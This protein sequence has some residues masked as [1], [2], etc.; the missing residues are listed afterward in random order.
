MVLLALDFLYYSAINYEVCRSWLQR[1]GLGGRW[2][3]QARSQWHCPPA[4][5]TRPRRGPP[6]PPRAPRHHHSLGE[7]APPP[8]PHGLH[9]H[10]QTPPS[11]LS[12]S[13]SSGSSSTNT[14][15]SAHLYPLQLHQRYGSAD[16]LTG[17]QGSRDSGLGGGWLSQGP[18]GCENGHL[19]LYPSSSVPATINTVGTGPGGNTSEFSFLSALF[20]VSPK[21]CPSSTRWLP[22]L[23]VP[24]I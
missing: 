5:D 7:E 20:A 17:W 12:S 1:W 9:H 18:H 19:A 3:K 8:A 11:T 13:S 10:H 23:V 2:L 14:S 21:A 4:L 22:L 15:S 16:R 24:G 6:D